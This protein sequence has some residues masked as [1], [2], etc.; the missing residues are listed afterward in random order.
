MSNDDLTER[1]MVIAKRAA[2]LA[3]EEMQDEFYR[4]VGKSLAN[5]A[6]TIIGVLAVVAASYIWGTRGGR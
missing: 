1:E 2:K 4:M 6:L 3:V 5:R